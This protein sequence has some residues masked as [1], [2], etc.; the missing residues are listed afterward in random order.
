VSGCSTSSASFFLARQTGG[1]GEQTGEADDFVVVTEGDAA[2]VRRQALAA[3]KTRID[4][5]KT[6]GGGKQGGDGKERDL[7]AEFR[8]RLG[9]QIRR[10]AVL[11]H[12]GDKRHAAENARHARK[13]L[14]VTRRLD[15]ENVG[16]RL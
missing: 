6:G 14:H 1:L 11:D 5:L 3:G 10:L 7:V 16:P 2:L 9:R 15:E 12:V 13:L 4:I 8:E